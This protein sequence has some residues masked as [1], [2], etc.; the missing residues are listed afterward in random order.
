MSL[1]AGVRWSF[2]A[3]DAGRL[4][5]GSRYGGGRWLL[6]QGEP[7][8]VRCHSRYFAELSLVLDD[9]AV[10]E[11]APPRVR[12]H[13]QLG[14][15]RTQVEEAVDGA[16]EPAGRIRGRTAL[17][18]IEVGSSAAVDDVAHAV[19][20][21]EALVV[22]IVAVQHEL[23]AVLLEQRYPALDDRGIAPVLTAGPGRMVE[24]GDLP[25]G[26]RGG[27]H[28]LQPGRLAGVDAVRVE[29]E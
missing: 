22:V 12:A 18:G 16:G 13:P 28:R 6:P 29:D 3:A 21:P 7:A 20:R 11:S 27:Q 19:P 15:T 10:D 8:C 26:R 25:R 2:W 14:V 24:N 5:I 4:R 23:Y 1:V 17:D 9:D